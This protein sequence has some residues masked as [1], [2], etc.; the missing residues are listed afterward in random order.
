MTPSTHTHTLA[1]HSLVG[2]PLMPFPSHPASARQWR[3]QVAL[4]LPERDHPDYGVARAMLRDSTDVRTNGSEPFYLDSD[5]C[6]STVRTCNPAGVRNDSLVRKRRWGSRF[7]AALC[8]SGCQWLIA[9][10]CRQ[11]RG[12]CCASQAAACL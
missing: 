7:E 9:W 8:K 4:Y 2:T 6:I 3:P 5:G 11:E 12:V 1:M 10:G